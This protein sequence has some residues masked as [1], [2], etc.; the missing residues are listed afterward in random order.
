MIN[1]T[2]LG[3]GIL[4][5]NTHKIRITYW[6]IRNICLLTGL[7]ELSLGNA[8]NDS[9]GHDLPS[10]AVTT[11]V[12]KLPNLNKLHVPSPEINIFKFSEQ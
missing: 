7:T 8:A 10:Y 3:I 11:L 5:V 12:K 2:V 9:D 1:L 4:F 6:G